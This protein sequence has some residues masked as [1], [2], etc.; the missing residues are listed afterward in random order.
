[1]KHA[2]IKKLSRYAKGLL[3]TA[4]WRARGVKVLDRV[5]CAGL[6]PSIGTG[7]AIELG[8]RISFRG[9]LRR[10]QLGSASGAL[11]RI[12]D[13]CFINSGTSIEA[14]NRIEIGPHCLIGDDVLIQDSNY[15]EVGQGDG[16]TQ[17]PIVIGRNVWIANR[18]IIMPGVTIGDHSVIGAG[19][20]VTKDV[21][22][23]TVVGG[24]PARVIGTVTCADDYRR[25]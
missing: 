17:A 25:T 8:S 21:A 19:A 22:S 9:M 11:L 18:A 4:V 3:L 7:G 15:H 23:R 10:P 20:I 1:M 14:T 24:I 5:V 12:G 16:V 6:A 13:F 2:S